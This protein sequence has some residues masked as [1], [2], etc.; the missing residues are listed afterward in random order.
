MK[1]SSFT[2]LAIVVLLIGWAYVFMAYEENQEEQFHKENIDAA[3]E[4]CGNAD[5]DMSENFRDKTVV[6]NC[7][8]RK[9]LRG[10]KHNV[11]KK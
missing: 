3:R 7:H 8:I 1:S 10:G 9:P 5:W 11:S 2:Y 6:I 4:K